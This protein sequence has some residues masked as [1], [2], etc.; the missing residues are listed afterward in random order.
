[1]SSETV[2]STNKRNHKRAVLI[3]V[4]GFTLYALHV[5]ISKGF[6]EF[7]TGLFG[8]DLIY[9]A[10]ALFTIF[11]LFGWFLVYRYLGKLL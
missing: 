5:A 2:N 1:M 11:V 6:V 4:I 9:F 3:A 7:F 8:G 10:N